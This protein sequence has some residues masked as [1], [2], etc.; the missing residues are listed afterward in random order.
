MFYTSSV[1]HTGRHLHARENG[2]REKTIDCKH[3][4]NVPEI[5]TNKEMKRTNFGKYTV[6]SPVIRGAS[7]TRRPG[8]IISFRDAVVEIATQRS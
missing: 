2:S 1:A 5:N 6:F 4:K 7:M 3:P 8:A